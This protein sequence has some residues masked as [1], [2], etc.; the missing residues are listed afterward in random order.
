MEK[1]IIILG[2]S[3]MAWN[4]YLKFKNY[5]VPGFSSSDLFWKLNGN[6][7]IKGDVAVVMIG[8]NDILLDCYTEITF[9]SITNIIKI[10]KERFKK[11]LFVSI[12]PVM[13]INKN[14][15][16]EEVNLFIKS[17]EGIKVMDIY[18]LYLNK[19]N[20]IDYKFTSDGV[21]LNEYGYK[22]LNDKLNEKLKEELN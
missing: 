16:I 1:E 7:D 11:I 9:K 2:D 4:T 18:D 8:V 10:L 15:K 12:L 20:I 17:Q 6:E 13:Y 3:I 21:H 5:A 14:K 19:D 22:I